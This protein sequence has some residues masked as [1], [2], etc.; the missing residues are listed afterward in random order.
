M[1]VEPL[2]ALG[3]LP[4]LGP[5]DFTFEDD[6]SRRFK[7]RIRPVPAGISDPKKIATEPVPLPFQ[8]PEDALWFTYLSDSRTV[9]VNFRSFH[10]LQTQSERLWDYIGKLPA[11]A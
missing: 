7:L 5:A 1:S 10:E 2:A 9:Y 6:S 3:V 11:I 8:H 4:R